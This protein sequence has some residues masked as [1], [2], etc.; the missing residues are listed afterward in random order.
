MIKVRSQKDVRIFNF[1]KLIT[2]FGYR[3]DVKVED[4]KNLG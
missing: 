3:P 1:F 4:F 2:K